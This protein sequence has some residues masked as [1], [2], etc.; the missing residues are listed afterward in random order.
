M[1]SVNLDYHTRYLRQIRDDKSQY[2]NQNIMS[3]TRLF[4]QLKDHDMGLKAARA[5]AVVEKGLNN[6]A[7]ARMLPANTPLIEPQY[8]IRVIQKKDGEIIDRREGKHGE[9][10]NISLHDLVSQMSMCWVNVQQGVTINGCTYPTKIDTGY[11]PFCN[12]HCLCHK[13]LNNHVR[14]HLW[15]LMFC[16]VGDCFYTTFDIKAMVPHVLEAHPD[17]GYLKSKKTTET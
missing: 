11:C 6:Y 7:P 13:T 10:K 17:L 1:E 3:C 8:F 14:L 15:L 4:R 9:D 12:Y 5:K 2:P 16:R